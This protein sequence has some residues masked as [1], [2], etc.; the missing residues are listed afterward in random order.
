MVNASCPSDAVHPVEACEIIKRLLAKRENSL[1]LKLPKHVEVKSGA[2]NGII[3]CDY[4]AE[5]T[6]KKSGII[7]F[8]TVKTV[9]QKWSIVA[10]ARG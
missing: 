6:I 3:N 4:G 1:L 8:Y 9:C 7:T 2:I 5:F 10:L